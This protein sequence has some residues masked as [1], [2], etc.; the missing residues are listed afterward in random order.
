M[1]SGLESLIVEENQ[2]VMRGEKLG[3][4]PTGVIKFELRQG[5]DPIDP[6]EWIKIDSF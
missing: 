6:I 4:T 3:N 5:R 1:Y 2:V